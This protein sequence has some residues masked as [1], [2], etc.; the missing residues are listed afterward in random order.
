MRLSELAKKDVININDGSKIGNITDILIDDKGYVLSLVVDKSNFS[1]SFFTA[2]DVML[3]D[4]NNI[5]KIGEDVII[6][7][8]EKI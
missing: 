5:E 8:I 1:F 4:F 3:I 2:K 7:K 6:V